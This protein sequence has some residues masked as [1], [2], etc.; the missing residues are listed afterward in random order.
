MLRQFLKYGACHLEAL[1]RWLIRIGCGAYGDLLARLYLAKFLA[2]QVRGVL[3]DVDLALEVQ[4]IAHLHELMGVARVAVFAG[5][6]AAPVRI[7]GPAEGHALDCAAVQQRLHRQCEVFDIVPFANGL[8]LGR[9][10]R[11]ANKLRGIGR[12]KKRQ[13]SHCDSPFVR[14]W[15]ALS[16]GRSREGRGVVSCGKNSATPTWVAN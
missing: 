9:Q 13:G 2:K 11:D 1:F 3:L 6:L 7:D 8:S 12:G 5:K 15:Y 14:L 4:A 16:L 10:A